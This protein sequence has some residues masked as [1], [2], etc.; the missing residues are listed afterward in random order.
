MQAFRVLTSYCAGLVLLSLTGCGFNLWDGGGSGPPSIQVTPQLRSVAVNSTTVF[1]ASGTLDMSRAVW[2]TQGSGLVAGNASLGSIAPA[3][4]STVSYT[5]PSVPPVYPAS[6]DPLTQG[7]VGVRANI[8]RV[9]NS[10]DYGADAVW[11]A[12]TAPSVTAGLSPATATIS[13]GSGQQ[14]YGY[15]V[16]GSDV[17]VTFL[18]NGVAGGSSEVGTISSAG[19]YTA[20]TALPS[21]GSL[22]TLTLV[23]KADPTKTASASITLQ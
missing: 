20:P 4:G 21:T 9:G 15:A 23:S 22:V 1:T 10:N 7:H 3:N 13:L 6:A 2:N 17:S 8:A 14:F 5:A 12:I 18:V 16:G 11:V 19:Y